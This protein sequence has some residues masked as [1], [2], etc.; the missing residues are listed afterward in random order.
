MLIAVHNLGILQLLLTPFKRSDDL[1]A[2]S[3]D[4]HRDS[5]NATPKLFTLPK[6]FS[7]C[8]GML[9]KNHHAITIVERMESYQDQTYYYD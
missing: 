7:C 5:V 2:Y 6:H 8:R 9:A 1:R 4:Y 3:N